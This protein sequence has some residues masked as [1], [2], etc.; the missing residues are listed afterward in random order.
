MLK[1]MSLVV[2]GSQVLSHV[3]KDDEK[4]TSEIIYLLFVL[5]PLN[6]NYVLTLVVCLSSADPQ[7]VVSILTKQL[8]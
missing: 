3:T 8:Q 6:R 7:F 5:Y 4:K 1:F 2:A